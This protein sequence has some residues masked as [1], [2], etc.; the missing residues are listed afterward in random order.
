MSESASYDRRIEQKVT[1]IAVSDERMLYA[2]DS[3]EGMHLGRL[4]EQNGD[5]AEI[6]QS[7]RTP[8][9]GSADVARRLTVELSTA[10]QRR[11]RHA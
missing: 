6:D 4:R 8:W 5:T 11:G 9:I 7:C 3:E 1:T 10:T 2:A